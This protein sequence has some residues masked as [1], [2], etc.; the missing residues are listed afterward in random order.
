MSNEDNKCNLSDKDV[1]R[2]AKEMVKQLFI[3][4]DISLGNSLRRK[5][6]YILVIVILLAGVLLHVIELPG[7]GK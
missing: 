2:I 5:I 3:S 7:A 6:V 4:I 1:E